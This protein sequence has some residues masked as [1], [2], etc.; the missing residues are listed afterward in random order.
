MQQ[1]QENG[2][3]ELVPLTLTALSLSASSFW[4]IFLFN[5]INLSPLLLLTRATCSPTSQRRSTRTSKQYT[6]LLVMFSFMPDQSGA[7][8]HSHT[9]TFCS[10]D[11]SWVSVCWFYILYLDSRKST[12][13]GCI[14]LAKLTTDVFKGFSGACVWSDCVLCGS[15][16]ERSL[17]A[18]VKPYLTFYNSP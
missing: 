4:P 10:I 1:A 3:K 7:S 18:A 14:L 11:L 16:S 9:Y 12:F 17:Y 5:N 2:A 8:D 13:F 6:H 15:A